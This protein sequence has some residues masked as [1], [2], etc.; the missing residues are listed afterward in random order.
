MLQQCKN[1]HLETISIALHFRIPSNQRE[2]VYDSLFC[3][4]LF[5][6][7]SIKGKIEPVTF[8]FA[9]Q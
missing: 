5:A 2:T 1:Y 7:L 9:V 4:N 6:D 3:V 8:V